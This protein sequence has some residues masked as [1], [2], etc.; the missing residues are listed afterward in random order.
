MRRAIL[1]ALIALLAACGD[2]DSA[3]STTTASSAATTE[4]T[5]ST[6]GT[7]TSTTGA[8]R[9]Q[10]EAV[11]AWL[12]DNRDDV[13]SGFDGE[14]AGPCADGQI[15]VLCTIDRED[16]GVRAIV[17]VG[18]ASSDWGADLLLEQGDGGWTVVEHWAW[19]LE[20]DEPG[21]PFSPLTALAE[22]WATTDPDAVLVADCDDIDPSIT[23]QRLVCAELVSANDDVRRYRTGAPPGV[24][25]HEVEVRYEA[26]H[27]W[28]V[29]SST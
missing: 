18:V 14:F 29:T 22:W 7:S 8:E 11:A 5:T 23:D 6:T 21:P 17:G 10:Q 9:S 4:G 28:S 27:T 19:D 12:E 2:D 25:E 15:E 26:D 16:L 20:S 3:T 13:F 24:D 1:V